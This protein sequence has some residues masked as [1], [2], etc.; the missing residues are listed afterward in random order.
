MAP[1]FTI[2]KKPMSTVSD[3]VQILIFQ[4]SV[5]PDEDAVCL[6]NGQL[7]MKLHEYRQFTYKRFTVNAHKC[8]SVYFIGGMLGL[9]NTT[10]DLGCA[11]G[12]DKGE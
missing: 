3:Y 7:P 10:L 11:V 9:G 2:L 5:A 8:F 1:V 12:E 4:W 6:K